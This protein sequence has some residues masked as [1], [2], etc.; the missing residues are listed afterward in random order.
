LDDNTW[1]ANNDVYAPSNFAFDPDGN[2]IS[3][4]STG[5]TSMSASHAVGTTYN[6]A[7][8]LLQ[9]AIPTTPGAHDL[10]FSI[11]DQ[12][13]RDL[14]SAVFIDNIRFENEENGSSECT[15]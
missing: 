3:V 15:A 11:F 6:G 7:T 9:A 2:P 8:T 14:D 5:I 4:N 1:I 10:Y 13:D 12:L